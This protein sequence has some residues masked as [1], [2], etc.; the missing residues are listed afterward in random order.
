MLRSAQTHPDN[1]REKINI[2]PPACLP[3]GM[4]IKKQ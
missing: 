4:T 2:I 1:Y 3:T